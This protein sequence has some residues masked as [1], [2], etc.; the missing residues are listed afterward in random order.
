MD[1]MEF[2]VQRMKEVAMIPDPEA[3]RRLSVGLLVEAASSEGNN[4]HHRHLLIHILRKNGDL[5]WEL[6]PEWQ[7]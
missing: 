4:T 2:L 1:H 6:P 5:Q 7:D 3:R